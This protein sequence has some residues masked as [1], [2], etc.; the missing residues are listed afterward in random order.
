MNDE[1]L[2]PLNQRSKSEQRAIQSKGG[3][4]SGRARSMK[5]IARKLVS[6]NVTD[7]ETLSILDIC[8]VKE[9][10]YQTAMVLMQILKATQNADTEAF[11]TVLALLDE[12]VRSKEL[13]LKKE[14]LKLK[15]QKECPDAEN[16]ELN[17]LFK[18]IEE[19]LNDISE[20]K[21]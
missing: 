7:D 5:S 1:N 18:V 8:N 11:K 3:K 14:E 12:D 15:K 2:I 20:T 4:A 21:P 16:N 10:D 9:K 17:N 13:K 19:E 6:E